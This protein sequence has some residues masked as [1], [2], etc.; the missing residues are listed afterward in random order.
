MGRLADTLELVK[1]SHTLFALPFAAAAALAAAGGIPTNR[2]CGG[3]LL[4]MVG[5]R[6]AAMAFN[7]IADLRYDR[8]NPRTAMRPLVSGR[9]GLGWAWGV[10]G[11]SAALFVAACARLLN[12][13]C[14]LL[15]PVAL[16]WVL[17][18][19]YAKR[20][21]SA[22]HLWLGVGLGMAPVGAWAAV[23]G[24]LSDPAP[25]I[26]GTA[27]ALWTAGFDLLYACQDAEFDKSMGLHAVPAR[28]GIPV[29]LKLSTL[30]HVLAAGLLAGFVRAAGLGVISYGAVGG[31]ALLL[32]WEHRLV[33]PDDLSKLD[34]AFFTL[35][36]ASSVLI[37]AGVAVD[38]LR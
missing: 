23:R 31:M 4:A 10:T 12:P 5:A 19:S 3:I 28:F 36:A 25:W 8:E 18:Y 32:A 14:L 9:L 33:K 35:N 11:A 22:A 7:R 24:D 30:L 38:V 37:A 16:G 15:S 34:A 27:V 17:G 6:T 1:F 21:T 13:L 26:L 20:F 2:V 29:A